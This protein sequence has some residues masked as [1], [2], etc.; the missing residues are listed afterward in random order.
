MMTNSESLDYMEN[1]IEIYKTQC[2]FPGT[3]GMYSRR[4]ALKNNQDMFI[5]DDIFLGDNSGD[6]SYTNSFVWSLS[7]PFKLSHMSLEMRRHG[8]YFENPHYENPKID[9]SEIRDGF[10]EKIKYRE[11]IIFPL[12]LRSL[13]DDEKCGKVSN[14]KVGIVYDGL[15]EDLKD[16]AFLRK[17]YFVQ[18]K[19]YFHDLYFEAYDRF[20]DFFS[21]KGVPKSL[22]KKVSDDVSSK[23]HAYIENYVK[24]YF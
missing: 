2:A 12:F 3:R 20:M 19:N 14:I 18:E 11:D 17:E 23:N 9:Y 15:F 5:I 13:N 16:V 7:T 1:E 24:L 6:F 10:H 21:G 22:L 4:D 8:I